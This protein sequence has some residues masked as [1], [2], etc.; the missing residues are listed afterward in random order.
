M[1]PN[2]EPV[3]LGKKSDLA[4]SIPPTPFPHMSCEVERL[5]RELG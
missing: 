5:D 4:L 2:R 3:F 1:K